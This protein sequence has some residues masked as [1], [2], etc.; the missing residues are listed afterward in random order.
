MKKYFLS[1]HHRG[2]EGAIVEDPVILIN[3][4]RREESETRL[5]FLAEYGANFRGAKLE[6]AGGCPAPKLVLQ[7]NDSQNM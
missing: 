6:W 2:G 5:I 4:A 7:K 1:V 3:R